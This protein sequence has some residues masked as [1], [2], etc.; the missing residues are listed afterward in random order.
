MAAVV[1]PIITKAEKAAPVNVDIGNKTY[2]LNPMVR[3]LVILF[4]SGLLVRR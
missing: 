3:W 2:L 4:I 1:D